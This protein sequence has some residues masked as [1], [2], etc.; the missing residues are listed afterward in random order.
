MLS[1]PTISSATAGAGTVALAWSTVSPPPGGSVT[2]YVSREGAGA[3]G[4]CPAAA[5]PTSATSCTD[6]GLAAG[7]YH[8]TV[9]AVWRSWQATSSSTP[10]TLASGALHHF[11]LA[12]A[13]TTPTAGAADNLTVT[14]KDSAGNTVT[15][16]GGDQTVTFSG[17][18]T[19]GSNQPT[20]TSKTGTAVAFGTGETITF[21]S[22]VSTVA[23]S[24]NGVMTL[25]KAETAT[26]TVSDGTH[27]GNVGVTVAPAAAASYAVSA[28]GSATAG[29]ALSASLTAKDTYGNTATGYT[30]SHTID[31]SGPHLSPGGT[32]P[33]YPASVTFTSGAGPASVTL[34]DAETT[35]LTAA[36]H[37]SPAITGT[38]SSIVVGSGTA[39]SL[40]T[41]AASTTP[42][43]GAADNLTITAKDT[44][45]NI[46][47]GYTGDK[48]LP[49][50]ARP[51]AA[52]GTRPDGGLE[53]RDSGQ[54]RH[55]RDDR[56]HERR[57][58][59]VSSGSN[60]VMT[61]YKVENPSITVSD[62]S[63]SNGSGLSV[64]VSAGSIASLAVSATST[65]PTAGAADNLTITAQ[66]HVAST[67]PPATPAARA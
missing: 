64:T 22:G 37:A 16:Y 29:S 11:S 27:T 31:F 39:A 26:V 51:P 60:G 46:A 33:S 42:T 4:N 49:S 44:W 18:S 13:T 59:P 2:Y 53:D 20:V 30:G 3:G 57:R 21:T 54:L 23:G 34:Y 43:A 1:A 9:T 63:I 62:G 32:S 38:S 66:G 36:D 7:T 35:T 61:L 65:T 40:S 41:F 55:R 10:V 67:P 52:S 28:P 25:Y 6:S 15:A 45:L 12:A 17:A 48:S 58:R 56:V 47:T 19:I 24:S 5:S 14:A 8:Y 50:A